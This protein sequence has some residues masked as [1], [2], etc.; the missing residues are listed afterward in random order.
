MMRAK[1]LAGNVMVPRVLL[2]GAW[3]CVRRPRIVRRFSSTISPSSCRFRA[4]LAPG[5]QMSSGEMDSADASIADLRGW[6]PPSSFLQLYNP[7]NVGRG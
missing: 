3:G 4:I 6:L 1:S 2:V 7:Y 5:L